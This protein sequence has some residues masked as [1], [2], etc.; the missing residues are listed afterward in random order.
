MLEAQLAMLRFSLQR[1]LAKALCLGFFLGEMC[2]TLCA[3]PSFWAGL[4]ATLWQP[5]T[6]AGTAKFKTHDFL[7]PVLHP[8]LWLD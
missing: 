3:Q 7:H 4:H 6:F 8:G 1:G 2:P 5:V